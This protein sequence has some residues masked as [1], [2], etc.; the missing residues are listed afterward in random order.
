MRERK[1]AKV[2]ISLPKDLLHLAD[3]LALERS[4]TRSGVLAELLEKE[5]KAR[6]RALM[7]EGYYEMADENSR[8]A[9]EFFSVASEM[10]LRNTQWD[11]RA[12]G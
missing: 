7:E 9:G 1:V 2:T 11:E 3:R 4:S 12:R 6:V 5:G 10:V 8:L